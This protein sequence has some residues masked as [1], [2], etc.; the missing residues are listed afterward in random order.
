M[1][2]GSL[3]RRLLGFEMESQT[4]NNNLDGSRHMACITLGEALVY[5][6]SSII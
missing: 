4:S 6:S 3:V 2:F 1:Q 5:Y